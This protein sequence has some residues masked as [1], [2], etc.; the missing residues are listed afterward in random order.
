ME[1]REKTSETVKRC[2]AERRSSDER[3][4]SLEG[5]KEEK[6]EGEERVCNV[7]DG[8]MVD[9]WVDRWMRTVR[10]RKGVDV[11]GMNKGLIC[12]WFR[13]I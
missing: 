3:F 8:W 2:G 12:I 4:M 11:L 5:G 7:D 9:G 10:G 6:A 1:G 13:R